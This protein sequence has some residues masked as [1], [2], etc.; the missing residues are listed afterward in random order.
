MA[1]SL[2]MPRDCKLLPVLTP[3]L[4]KRPSTLRRVRKGTR[5][6]SNQDK[7]H[8]QHQ[9]KQQQGK[10]HQGKQYQGKQQKHHQK[11]SPGQAV[12]GQT[13]PGEAAPVQHRHAQHRREQ[14]RHAQNRNAQ[15]RHK[16]QVIRD[17]VSA[18]VTQTPCRAAACLPWMAGFSSVPGGGVLTGLSP[19]QSVPYSC[20]GS[21]VLFPQSL[22]LLD[23]EK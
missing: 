16:Y 21:L 15:H 7:H 18:R 1:C 5:A 2:W 14:H 11:A 22:E 13:I 12:P 10:K 9:G 23:L 17:Q 3:R 20:C 4:P 8:K 6:S 19:T